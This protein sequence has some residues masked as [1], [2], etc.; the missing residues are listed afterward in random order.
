MT[1]TS[2]PPGTHAIIHS[3]PIFSAHFSPDLREFNESSLVQLGGGVRTSGPTWPATPMDRPPR[4][5]L[6]VMC[7]LS[8]SRSVAEIRCG[9]E[10]F[11]QTRKTAAHF[12]RI[13]A[14]DGRTDGHLATA[15]RAMHSNI[16][17]RGENVGRPS[18][19]LIL[20]TLHS[21]CL[22]YIRSNES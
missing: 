13:P 17:S 7:R 11:A 6:I 8:G 1:Q 5:L 21:L 9:V 18:M 4:A 16:A 20:P 15:V 10:P 14:C 22:A 3:S 12:D 2:L 19:Q